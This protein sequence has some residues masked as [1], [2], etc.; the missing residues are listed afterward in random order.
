MRITFLSVVVTLASAAETMRPAIEGCP[1]PWKVP[2]LDLAEFNVSVLVPDGVAVTKTN[3]SGD[4]GAGAVISIHSGGID[5]NV[6]DDDGDAFFQVKRGENLCKVDVGSDGNAPGP[7]ARIFEERGMRCTFLPGAHLFNL[8]LHVQEVSDGSADCPQ[9]TSLATKTM[10][11]PA[12]GCPA[13]WKVPNFDLDHFNVSVSVPDGVTVTK[14]SRNGD[15]GAGADLHIRSGGVDI[16]VWNDDGD[17]YFQVKRGE[18]MC[19]VDVGSDG[20]AAGPFARVFEE[21]GMRCTFLEGVHRF[22][23]AMRSEDVSDGSA[24]CPRMTAL[25][26]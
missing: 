8:A 20:E 2:N 16:R 13:P 24:D 12:K 7:V 22:N 15:T 25:V 1:A 21:R 3:R 18:N 6:Q 5:V 4:T 17:A 11:P 14:A 19:K 23:L 9:P 26:V 10:W